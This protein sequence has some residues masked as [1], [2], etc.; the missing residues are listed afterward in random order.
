MSTE[1]ES[2]EQEYGK[3][4]YLQVKHLSPEIQEYVDHLIKEGYTVYLQVVG[5]VDVFMQVNQPNASDFNYLKNTTKKVAFQHGNPKP[6]C[7][8]AGCQ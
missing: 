3:K 2:Q 1:Q 4:L 8:P 6:P 7:P 5:D